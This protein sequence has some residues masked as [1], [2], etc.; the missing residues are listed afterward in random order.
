MKK[1]LRTGKFFVDW[2]QNDDH[3]TTFCAYSLRAKERPTVSTPVTWEEVEKCHRQQDA[4]LL[5]FE[6]DAI[7]KR[8]EKQKD[9]FAPVLT[10]K[11]KL[12]KLEAL[13]QFGTAANSR[14]VTPAR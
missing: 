8:I 5:V 14:L 13:E 9:L 4:S 10:L 1:S 2:I 11:Q 3:K 12:P 6:T 7:L